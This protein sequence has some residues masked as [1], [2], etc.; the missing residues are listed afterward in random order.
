[1][2]KRPEEA[3]ARDTQHTPHGTCEYDTH[4]RRETYNSRARKPNPYTPVHWLLLRSSETPRACVSPQLRGGRLPHGWR[5]HAVLRRREAAQGSAQHEHRRLPVDV[6]LADRVGRRVVGREKEP[7]GQ[8]GRA[9]A[10]EEEAA[11][12]KDEAGDKGS[13]RQ[14]L[15]AVDGRPGVRWASLDAGKA[16]L[17]ALR[18]KALWGCGKRPSTP[19]ARG[20]DRALPAPLQA[21]RTRASGASDRAVRATERPARGGRYE[22]G[23]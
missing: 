17:V 12:Q 7:R 16:V 11:A 21:G 10:R 2:L 6:A 14:D 1:M 18:A 19:L 4:T 23:C 5:P 15:R 22:A 20:A 8:L 13:G 3:T 9:E